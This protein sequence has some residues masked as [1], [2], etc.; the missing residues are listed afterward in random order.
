MKHSYVVTAVLFISFTSYGK[1]SLGEVVHA[2][3]RTISIQDS[4]GNALTDYDIYIYR[5]SHPGSQF[6]EVFTFKGQKKSSFHTENITKQARKQHEPKPYWVACVSKK[7]FSDKR[8]SLDESQGNPLL[9]K[10][11]AS[12]TPGPDACHTERAACTACRS[13]EYFM[14]EPMRYRHAACNVAQ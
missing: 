1:L 7:G 12:E 14:Y 10:L 4:A 2:P 6:H 8:W 11:Q 9:I 5:C 13:Y 3:E